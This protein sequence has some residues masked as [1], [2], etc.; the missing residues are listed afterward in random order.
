MPLA[1]IHDLPLHVCICGARYLDY[2][3]GRLAHH[4]VF[5]HNPIHRPGEEPS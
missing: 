5:G 4:V 1:A 3:D 2:D